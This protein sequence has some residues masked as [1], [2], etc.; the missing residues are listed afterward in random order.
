M[1]IGFQVIL[2]MPETKDLPKRKVV[3]GFDFGLRNIGVAVGQSITNTA[4]PLTTLKATDGIPNWKEIEALI[5]EWKPSDIVVGVPL[6]LEGNPEPI[7]FNARKF[8]NRLRSWYHL[9]VHEVDERLTSWE[10]KERLE[11]LPHRKVKS[12][13]EIHAISAVV[14]VEQWM[15]GVRH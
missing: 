5:E 10:A 8:M 6:S 11:S 9:P 14:I 15:K 4:S 13:N 7:A 1:S 12:K 3:L 2:A